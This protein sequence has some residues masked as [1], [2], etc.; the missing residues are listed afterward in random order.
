M[1]NPTLTPTCAQGY[2]IYLS[3]A[4]TP[5]LNGTYGG[6]TVTFAEPA[7]SYLPAPPASPAAP[8]PDVTVVGTFSP[9]PVHG[10]R[11]CLVSVLPACPQA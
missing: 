6:V 4:A 11:L 5:V 8:P 7:R 2:P 10:R 1:R 3:P 9:P